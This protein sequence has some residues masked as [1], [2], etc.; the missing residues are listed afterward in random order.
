MHGGRCIARPMRRIADAE[1]FASRAF[2]VRQRV[3]SIM[4]GPFA[5][6]SISAL[7][8]LTQVKMRKKRI[9]NGIHIYPQI[10]TV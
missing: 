9:N 10:S 8:R 7:V 1:N 4:P 6:L 3:H 5:G 2:G